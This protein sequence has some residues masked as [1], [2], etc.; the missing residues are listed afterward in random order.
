[1]ARFGGFVHLIQM[2]SAMYSIFVL[3]QFMNSCICITRTD[4][5][6]LANM[7]SFESIDELL[8]GLLALLVKNFNLCASSFENVVYNPVI[9]SCF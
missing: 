2:G 4:Q 9:T 6:R 8:T 7:I 5:R 3:I 1:M